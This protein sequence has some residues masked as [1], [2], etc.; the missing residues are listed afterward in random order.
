MGLH[1]LALTHPPEKQSFSSASSPV[2][3]GWVNKRTWRQ[4]IS[5]QQ[6]LP[7]TP[8]RAK[9]CLHRAGLAV[10]QALPEAG[11][12]SGSGMV[13]GGPPLQLCW[14]QPPHCTTRLPNCLHSPAC[15]CVCIQRESPGG[16][17][18][19]GKGEGGVHWPGSVRRTHSLTLSHSLRERLA[20]AHSRREPKSA[21]DSERRGKVALAFATRLLA[22]GSVFAPWLQRARGILCSPL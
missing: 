11:A 22:L 21:P 18:G 1:V 7:L 13:V 5:T 10:A 12:G 6:S 14:A 15:E 19:G 2:L 17:G 8:S 9:P 3:G 4:H 20:R 16:G